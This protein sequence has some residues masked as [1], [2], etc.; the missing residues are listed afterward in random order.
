MR[1]WKRKRKRKRKRNIKSAKNSQRR[2][3][4]RRKQG[5]SEVKRGKKINTTFSGWHLYTNF[6]IPMRIRIWIHAPVQPY[7]SVLI[8]IPYLPFLFCAC[9]INPNWRCYSSPIPITNY[10]SI[11]YFHITY[12]NNLEIS[13]RLVF[14]Y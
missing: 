2:V 4:L 3:R 13:R 10:L 11:P 7:V 5:R 8:L 14:I 12:M 1:S 9:E 6:R